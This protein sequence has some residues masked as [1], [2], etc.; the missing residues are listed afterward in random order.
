MGFDHFEPLESRRLLSTVTGA[1]IIAADR[2][3]LKYATAQWNADQQT[4]PALLLADSA[5]ITSAQFATVHN[6]P[7]KRK[8]E[9]DEA[10]APGIISADQTA[11]T[12]AATNELPAVTA[13]Y[14]QI[15]AD[16]GN[17]TALATDNTNLAND[18]AAYNAAV[19]AAV[20]QLQ[21]D[22]ASTQ[23]NIA[24]DKAA[25]AALLQATPAYT[26]AV[27][28]LQADGEILTVDQTIADAAGYK[29]QVSN[30]DFPGEVI[31]IG[32]ILGVGDP[33]YGINLIYGEPYGAISFD[34]PRSSPDTVADTAEI[35]YIQPLLTAAQSTQTTDLS[36][37]PA[38][39]ADGRAA[40]VP[41]SNQQ[42]QLRLDQTNAPKIQAVD[43]AA[44]A[45]AAANHLGPVIA[46]YEQIDADKGAT[47]KIQKADAAQLAK[48]QAAFYGLVTAA[49]N[50]GFVDAAASDAAIAHDK[51]AIA[52]LLQATPAY[53]SAIAKQQTDT[54]TDANN[55]QTDQAIL[56]AAQAKLSVDTAN[57]PL[58]TQTISVTNGSYLSYGL[59]GGVWNGP[60]LPST[61]AELANIALPTSQP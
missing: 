48:D 61:A 14:K 40:V 34:Q 3:E 24:D 15:A 55:V 44:I 52:E 28:K 18:Q 37:D 53:A 54:I 31:L 19:S 23:K 29:V 22:Q 21:S 42:A 49:A 13:D 8:L 60:V 45:P 30:G 33:L 50:K 38:A 10:N 17:A 20:T 25:I 6:S 11:I 57:A 47:R 4:V 1:Q 5:A 32:S 58:V 27:A 59:R 7:Q 46:D 41:G 51:A 16:S 56:T 39:V 43:Q 36:T 12:T 9:S 26:S 2:K 35:N